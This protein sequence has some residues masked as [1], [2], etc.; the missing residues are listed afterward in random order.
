MNKTQLI[1]AIRKEL[2]AEA[3]K[4]HAAD[5]LNATLN[6]IA[7]A[8][9]HE[10]VQL[11]GFG[12]FETKKRPARNGRNPRTGQTIKIKASSVVTFRA[13]SSLKKGK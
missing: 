10:K 12:T 11:V 5:A 8:V 2:G 4:K 1:D 3:T 6:A 9:E 7:K 13:S